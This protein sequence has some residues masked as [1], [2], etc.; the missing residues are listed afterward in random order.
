AN[1]L[2]VEAGVRGVKIGTVM[3]CLHPDGSETPAER[4]RATGDPAP[5]SHAVTH[6]LCRGSDDLRIDSARAAAGY[7]IA[8]APK[9]LRAFTA[10]FEPLDEWPGPKARREFGSSLLSTRSRGRLS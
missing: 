4:S 3:F 5:R 7:R 10:A 1:A 6:R 2:Y 8:A 9:V